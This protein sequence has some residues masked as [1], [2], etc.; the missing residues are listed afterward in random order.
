MLVKD[1]LCKFASFCSVYSNTRTVGVKRADTVECHHTQS[2]V[3]CDHR[4]IRRDVVYRNSSQLQQL[5]LALV[6]MCR[7]GQSASK[8]E[9]EVSQ[10]VLASTRRL[11]RRRITTFTALASRI[12]YSTFST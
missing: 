7:R 6:V 12:L 8:L 4:H 1:I 3:L 11:T 10:Q 5:I 2:D 9:V